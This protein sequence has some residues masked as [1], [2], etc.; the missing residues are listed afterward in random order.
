MT[1]DSQ[2]NDR[3]HSANPQKDLQSRDGRYTNELTGAIDMVKRDRFELLSAYLDGEVTAAERKQVEE[4]LATDQTV[5]YLYARLLKLR[6]GVR[7]LPVPELLQQSSQKTAEQVLAR[8]QR[9]SR[10]VWLGGAAVAACAIGAMS[11]LLGESRMSQFAQQRIERTQETPTAVASPLMVAINNP[12]I[13]IPKTAEVAP[14][15][16]V[17][18]EVQP[19]DL[20]LELDDI[21]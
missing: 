4:W 13:P 16:S 5:Q 3:S 8:V 19:P 17:H 18:D 20:L 7:T 14:E 11:G 9:R 10:L 15:K 12:V 1:T 2:F 6:Q 21:N